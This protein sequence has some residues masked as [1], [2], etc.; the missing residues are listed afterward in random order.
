MFRLRVVLPGTT[1]AT[2]GHRHGEELDVPTKICIAVLRLKDSYANAT[3]NCDG[4]RV[5]SYFPQ[6]T[7]FLGLS[8]ARFCLI[9]R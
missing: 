2:F 1:G 5:C 7:F 3:P 8:S 9:G 4:V 6:A